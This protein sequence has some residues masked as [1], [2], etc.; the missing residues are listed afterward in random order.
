[1]ARGE[2]AIGPKHALDGRENPLF[3]RAMGQKQDGQGHRSHR[4]LAGKN[5]FAG[6]KRF[7]P[8]GLEGGLKI[9]TR[10]LNAIVDDADLVGQELFRVGQIVARKHDAQIHRA[11]Q[12]VGQHPGTDGRGGLQPFCHAGGV[13]VQDDVFEKRPAK[14]HHQPVA[15]QR[16]AFARG[17]HVI[18]I[19]HS[20]TKPQPDGLQAKP[21]NE[22]DLGPLKLAHVFQAA[23]EP[24][25]DMI[26]FNSP[27]SPVFGGPSSRVPPKTLEH[28]LHHVALAVM[29][30]RRMGK[31]K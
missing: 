21:E 30:R 9:G 14:Q 5:P 25:V 28:E 22:Q 7:Q 23:G 1:M 10:I 26:T 24:R 13:P 6:R 3:A 11:E 31:D 27:I 4:D 12:P 18:K 16:H 29:R 2:H 19:S 8:A 20:V 17:R 15:V